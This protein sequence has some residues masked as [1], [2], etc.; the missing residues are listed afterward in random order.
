MEADSSKPVEIRI[1]GD[2]EKFE[3]VLVDDQVV[4][5]K[6]YTVKKGSTIVTFTKEFLKSLTPGEHKVKFEF[7]DGAAET[8]L[9]VKADKNPGTQPGTHPGAHPGTEPKGK[10]P[11]KPGKKNLPS[12]GAAMAVLPIAGLMTAGGGIVLARKKENE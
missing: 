4:N 2:F 3:K 6:Y 1:S 5:P 11:V 7:T 9:N 10:A 8:T 12:T